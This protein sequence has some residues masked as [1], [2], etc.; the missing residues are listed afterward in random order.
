[1]YEMENPGAGSAA[2]GAKNAN[3]LTAKPDTKYTTDCYFDQAVDLWSE[4]RIARFKPWSLF[5]G[6]SRRVAVW[7]ELHLL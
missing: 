1:M 6:F 5:S 2:H 3:C 4:L 7:H